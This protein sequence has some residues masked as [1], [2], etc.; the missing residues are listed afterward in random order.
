[1][2]ICVS[3]EKN[4]TSV[5]I[6]ISNNIDLKTNRI[7]GDKMG[8]FIMVNNSIHRKLK[9]ILNKYPSSNMYMLQNM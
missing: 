5:A 9:Q 1:M 6:L 3:H 2:D 8:H 7:N 4:K